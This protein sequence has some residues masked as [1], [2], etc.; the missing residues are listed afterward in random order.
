[1]KYR[2][3]K[4]LA[5]IA[6][7]VLFAG[8][9]WAELITLPAPELPY[10]V[11][12]DDFYSYSVD[13]L[14][15]AGIIP[16]EP[17]GSGTLDLVI[18]AKNNGIDNDPVSGGL[19]FEDPLANT[20]N[21][22]TYSGNWMCDLD[23]LLDYLH[24]F[25]NNLNT[26]IFAFDLTEPNNVEDEFLY[27]S[28]YMTVIEDGIVV[29]GWSL[30]NTQDGVYNATDKV[31]APGELAGFDI[32]VGSG[33][34]DFLVYAETMNLKEYYGDSAKF[35]IYMEFSDLKAGGEEVYVSGR[36]LP[37]VPP[38]PVPEPGTILL[39]GLGFIGLA[40]FCRRRG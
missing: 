9:G 23:N 25:D 21:S 32:N 5:S 13:I 14:V 34:A 37:Y 26:P 33:E 10:A 16:N 22:D 3:S 36:F 2:F 6:T 7:I 20:G 17:T 11:R 30:D 39:F 8:S 12:Y 4:I 18:L 15:D 24:F 40:G 35:N 28:A 27:V 29:K 1:M 31:L 38:T 19:I